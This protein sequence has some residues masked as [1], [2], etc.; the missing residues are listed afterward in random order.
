MKKSLERRLSPENAGPTTP[1]NVTMTDASNAII[2]TAT[3]LN[4]PTVPPFVISSGLGFLSN[5]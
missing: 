1:V 5:F 2:G 4:S 3:L